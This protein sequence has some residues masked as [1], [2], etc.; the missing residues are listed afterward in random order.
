M[1]SFDGDADPLVNLPLFV[2]H[3]DGRIVG[4]RTD[5]SGTIEEQ[6]LPLDHSYSFVSGRQ[7]GTDA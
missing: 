4:L 5:D 6:G 7:Q 1:L 2:N 3:R